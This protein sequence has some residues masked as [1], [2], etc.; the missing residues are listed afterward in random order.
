[1]INTKYTVVVQIIKKPKISI[2]RAQ[3]I[4][5]LKTKNSHKISHKIRR[6]FA[7]IKIETDHSF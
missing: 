5:I 7:K 6:I 1:M 2:F 3:K 4:P